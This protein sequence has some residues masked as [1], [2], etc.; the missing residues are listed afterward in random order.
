VIPSVRLGSPDLPGDGRR[1]YRRLLGGLLA[2]GLA[3]RCYHFLRN[4]SMWH[5]E[6][7]LVLNVL[8]KTFTGLLGPLYFSE[9]APPLFLWIEKA[10]AAVLGDGTYALRLVPFLAS[11]LALL[12]LASAAHRLLPRGAALWCVLLAGCSDRLLWHACEAKPY[13]VDVLVASG[14]LVIFLRT[15][16]W[17]LGRQL[18]LYTCLSPGLIF[19]S[20]PACFLLGGLALCLLP[21]AW[22]DR[23]AITWLQFGGFLAVMGGSFLLL[24]LGPVHAQRDPRI[25]ECW[26][27]MFPSWD[28]P[29]TLPAWA[30]VRA[31]EVFRYAYEPVGNVLAAMAVVGA[32]GLWRRGQ[33]RLVAFLILPPALACLAALLGQYPFGATRVMGFAAPAA[34]FL[35]AAG[36][37]VSLLWLGRQARWCPLVLAGV[38]LFPVGQAAYRAVCPWERFDSARASAFVRGH[39]Q[40]DEAVLGT[41]W[42]HEYYFRDRRQAFRQV[43]PTPTD[44]PPAGAGQGGPG[45]RVWL[46][47][48]GKTEAE[49]RG[50]LQ[51]V[52]SSSPSVMLE[53][54]EFDRTTVYLLEK[55]RH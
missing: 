19:L 13:A 46:L 48:A 47:A 24:V 7:A 34:L 51:E 5:D 29:G 23:G 1:T 3:L 54:Y 37:P 49:R 50:Y 16:A 12:G 10:A 45:R 9:A 44:P 40:P 36:L 2:L 30:G 26:Q 14:L 6:A 33:R 55:T 41:A 42:E 18:L 8:G 28:R 32:I 17:P 38:A 15:A 52:Q 35:V 27:D 39:L 53:R 21:A 22:R 25:L 31:V 43:L 11:C 4:P 20:Y